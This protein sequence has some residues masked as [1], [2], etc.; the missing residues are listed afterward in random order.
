MADKIKISKI[1]ININGKTLHLS[2]KDAQELKKVL[3]DAFPEEERVVYKYHYPS[4][5]PYVT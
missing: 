1:Q 4:V 5:Y 2:L 3:N